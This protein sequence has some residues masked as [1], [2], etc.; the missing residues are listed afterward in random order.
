MGSETKTTWTCDLCP[1]QTTSAP[2]DM[3]PESWARIRTD[4]YKDICPNCLELIRKA[5]P[6]FCAR[7]V[8]VMKSMG[9]EKTD[10]T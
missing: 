6:P 3:P 9:E 4:A 2:S 7:C 5:V 8:Q 10:G 1:C